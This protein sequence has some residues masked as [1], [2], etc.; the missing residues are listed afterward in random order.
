MAS[1]DRTMLP[2]TGRSS[3]LTCRAQDAGMKQ[4]F[5]SPDGY[6][7]A[8][9]QVPK[10]GAHACD[11]SSRDRAEHSQHQW[12][13]AVARVPS[14]ATGWCCLPVQAFGCQVQAVGPGDSAHIRVDPYPRE[15]V[16]VAEVFEQ[17]A[18][19]ADIG[20]VQVPDAAVAE[21]KPQ[22]VVTEHLDI[23]YLDQ[24][25]VHSHDATLT[26]RSGQVSGRLAL[27]PR[28]AAVL[29]VAE[30]PTAQLRLVPR[31]SACWHTRARHRS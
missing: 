11:C 20:H 13:S 30:R 8:S 21:R 26:A 23:G 4:R 28:P 2:R 18:F 27:D 22:V 17:V 31:R 12:R 14:P 7:R 9:A 10:D 16:W 6:L 24:V 15:I 5:E 3:F 29:R 1:A 19:V 25:R